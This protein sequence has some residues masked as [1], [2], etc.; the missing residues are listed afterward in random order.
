MR[1]AVAMAA[2]L[3]AVATAA[4]I[5]FV[6]VR[7]ED[8]TYHVTARADI[9]AGFDAVRA[10]I[11]DYD[12]LWWISGAVKK[13]ERLDQPEPGV[14][15]IFVQTRAC[16]AIFCKTFDQIQHVDA[17]DR[18]RIVFE[19]LPQY[20]DVKRARSEWRMQRLDANHTRVEWEMMLEPDFWVPPLIGPRLVRKDLEEESYSMFRGVEKLAKEREARRR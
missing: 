18:E 19:A 10:V 5:D 17:R 15:A 1:F 3:P 6:H 16:F 8:D 11:T 4:E 20:S 7:I 9:A 2:L 13:S 12:H 14:T